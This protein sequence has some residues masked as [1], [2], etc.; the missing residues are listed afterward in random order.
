MS[1][2][3]FVIELEPDPDWLEDKLRRDGSTRVR[4]IADED[5]DTEGHGTAVLV[6][7]IVSDGLDTEGHAISLHFPSAEEAGAF[8]RRLMLT[9]ALAGTLALGAAGG[10]ALSSIQSAPADADAGSATVTRPALA[11]DSDIGIMD[12]SGAA[13]AAAAAAVT[14]PGTAADSDI[15]I[16]DASGA[17]AQGVTKSEPAEPVVGPR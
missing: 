12:A 2:Q 3:E 8:R 13:A 11:A 1:D 10:Y 15:G 9:G 17:A 14:Q 4:I 5:S 7:A 16:M 6:R